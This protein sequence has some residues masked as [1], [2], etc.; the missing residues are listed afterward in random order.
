M[1]IFEEVKAKIKA[2]EIDE[3]MSIAMSQALKLEI[4][5][6][7]SEVERQPS[8]PYLRTFIDL[9]DNE[10]E[11]QVSEQM[12]NDSSYNYIQQVHL[13]QME[14]GNERILKNIESLQKMFSL[15]NQTLSQLPD[16]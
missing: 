5:T 2:G 14:R 11:Y 4:V 13:E 16:N 15:L 10:I 9:L 8:P 6:C 12:M 3:A 7:L 1:S